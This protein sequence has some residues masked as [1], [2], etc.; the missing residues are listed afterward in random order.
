MLRVKSLILHIQTQTKKFYTA[1]YRYRACVALSHRN[2]DA[3]HHGD[4]AWDPDVSSSKH[5]VTDSMPTSFDLSP[6]LSFSI[7]S[8]G[9]SRH[10]D[11]TI[12][13]KHVHQ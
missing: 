3:D 10:F 13:I 11:E 2:H 12:A 5:D 1:N 9:K 4:A 7:F 6:S 8:Q